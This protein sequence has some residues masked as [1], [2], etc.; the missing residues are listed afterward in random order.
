MRRALPAIVLAL[1]VGVAACKPLPDPPTPPQGFDT[2]AAPSLDTMKRWWDSS[3]FTSV[4]IYVGGANRACAQPNLNQYWAGGA[5]YFGWRIIP[6]WVG[7]QAPCSHLQRVTKLP[8]DEHLSWMAGYTEAAAAADRMDALGFTWLAPV[9]YNMEAYPRDA[10]CARQVQA[11]AD[12]WTDG[13]NRRGYLAGMYSS[14]CSGIV[15]LAAGVPTARYP[16][17]AIWIAA[18][19]DTPNI[20]GFDIPPCPLK[21]YYWWNHQRLHQFKGGHDETWGGVTINI[22][23]NAVDGPTWPP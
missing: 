3:P 10:A 9:Y 16:V 19:N 13:L 14:L 11:F 17:N 22:D 20:F 6:I 18:W 21:D 8:A 23:S 12:G 1:A 5:A 2:C 7:P 15:D 4:G